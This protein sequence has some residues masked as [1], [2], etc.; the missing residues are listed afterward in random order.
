MAPSG[1]SSSGSSS[2]ASGVTTVTT[3]SRRRSSGC[4]MT[5][6]VDEASSWTLLG[7]FLALPVLGQLG[8]N[9]ILSMSLI[10]PLLPPAEALGISPT[11]LALPLVCGWTMTGITSPFTATTLLIARFGGIRAIQVGWVWNRGYF[12]A[13][14]ALLLTWLMLVAFLPGA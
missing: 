11:A 7:L 8:A 6:D 2:T 1:S 14:S 13:T 5:P 3:S 10:A 9:P 12:L 4:S